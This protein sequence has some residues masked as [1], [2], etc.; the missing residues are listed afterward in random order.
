[1]SARPLARLLALVALVF[2]TGRVRAQPCGA[3]PAAVARRGARHAADRPD[4][5]PEPLGFGLCHAFG[6]HAWCL[7]R[8]ATRAA[9]ARAPL[10]PS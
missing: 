5:D 7:A 6:A 1:M 8:A 10:P 9:S 3:V 4:V 2:P